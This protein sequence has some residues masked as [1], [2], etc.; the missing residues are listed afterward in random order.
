MNL[1][2]TTRS[3]Q[4]IRER[5]SQTSVGRVVLG[6]PV[7]LGGALAAG[8]LA[9]PWYACVP[10]VLF[11]LAVAAPGAVTGALKIV[12]GVLRDVMATVKPTPPTP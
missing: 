8:F 12:V 9:W 3:M 11:G 10:V 6:I 1:P 7:A 5:P 2:H 4:V